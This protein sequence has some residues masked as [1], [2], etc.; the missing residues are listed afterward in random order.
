VMEIAGRLHIF[1]MK[2]LESLLHISSI[3]FKLAENK[4][5]HGQN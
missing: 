4:T 3:E 2:D 5:C 1:W